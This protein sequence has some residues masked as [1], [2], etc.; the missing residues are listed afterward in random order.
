MALSYPG[1]VIYLN[2]PYLLTPSFSWKYKYWTLRNKPSYQ[3]DALQQK[4]SVEHN[5]S[6]APAILFFLDVKF[7]SI[8]Q[9]N[10]KHFKT[11]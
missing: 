5:A 9:E 3:I 10:T 7:F 4:I 6:D 1:V 8:F 2:A 11:C